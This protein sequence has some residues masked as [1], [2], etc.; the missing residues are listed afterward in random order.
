MYIERK[1][2]ACA[3]DLTQY[4]PGWLYHTHQMSPQVQMAPPVTTAIGLPACWE[5]RWALPSATPALPNQLA[6]ISCGTLARGHDLHCA[7]SPATLPLTAASLP[8][9]IQQLPMFPAF[10]SCPN[11]ISEKF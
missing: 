4:I 5:T 7:C 3:V 9:G 2:G 1:N 11:N 6:E 10:K 8:E